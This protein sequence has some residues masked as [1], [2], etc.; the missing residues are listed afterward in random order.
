[1]PEAG[2]VGLIVRDQKA[3]EAG[4]EKLGLVA[5]IGTAAGDYTIEVLDIANLAPRLHFHPE[6]QAKYD[7]AKTPAEKAAVKKTARIIIGEDNTIVE[8][9][10]EGAKA[11]DAFENQAYMIVRI[12]GGVEEGGVRVYSRYYAHYR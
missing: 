10:E 7:A 9:S 3:V 11:L 6:D 8:F 12:A 4:L 5:Q 2:V 1:M